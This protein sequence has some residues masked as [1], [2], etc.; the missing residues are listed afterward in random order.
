[1][2]RL[3]VGS[4]LAASLALSAC[5]VPDSPRTQ[6]SPAE[7]PALS[8]QAT[9]APATKVS[10]ES[11]DPDAIR[12][13]ERPIDAPAPVRADIPGLGGVPIVG[14]GVAAD[15]QAEIPEDVSRVG[16]YQYGAAPGDGDG[17]V[18]LMGHRDSRGGRGAL[19]D[20]PTVAVGSIVTVTDQAGVAHQYRVTSNESIAKK[21][22]PL[23]DLFDRDGPPRL[24]VISCGGDYV[25]E[26]GGYLDNVVLTAVPV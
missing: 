9:P 23:A 20:L 18:A 10:R 4:V 15:G 16:W 17:S 22:V 8:Q 19:F 21:V 7:A 26:Q 11:P 24:V 2:R 3:I 1:M 13:V 14:V 12:V 6:S 5:A 25:K